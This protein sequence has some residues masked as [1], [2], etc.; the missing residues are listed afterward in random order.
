MNEMKVLNLLNQFLHQGESLALAT[1]TKADGSSPGKEGSF[2]IVKQSGETFGTVGGGAIEKT[3]TNQSV[4]CISKGKGGSF[5]Y[6]LNMSPGSV[7]MMCGGSVEV[8]I[9]VFKKNPQLWIVGGGHIALYLYKFA[10]L[11]NFDIEIFEDREEYA[12]Q[13]RFPNAKKINI[14]KTKDLLSEKETIGETFAVV[15]TRGHRHDQEAVECLIDKN[16]KYIGMIGSKNKVNGSVEEL[17]KKGFEKEK[18]DSI[19][20]PIGINLKGDSPEEIAL[21]IIS[22]IVL[23][24]NN[25]N[26]FHLK[27]IKNETID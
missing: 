7:G 25:G 4:D 18:I 26:L 19:F 16:I 3:I 21:S 10:D 8:Y 13:E 5:H 1:V 23:I 12:C 22:Q 20:A 2:M 17:R 24:K 27:D 9:K 14:G 6:G 15:V 11:L